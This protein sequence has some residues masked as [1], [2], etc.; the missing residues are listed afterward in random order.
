MHW[1]HFVSKHMR[2][3][4][5]TI[6]IWMKIDPYY[7][8]RRCS[9]VTIVSGNIKFMR[10]FTAVP[11]RRGAS[12]DSGSH[13]KRRFS[14]IRTLRFRNFSK[15]GQ[16]YYIVLFSPLSPFQ[17]FQNSWPWMAIADRD[18]QVCS[19]C[20]SCHNVTIGLLI[21]MYFSSKYSCPQYLR[22]RSSYN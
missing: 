13:R 16:Y 2:L 10:I 15:W 8:R 18:P 3:S 22:C 12:N 21:Y 9:T 11:W 7:Q 5:P 20:S 17:W 19:V 4:E 14:G 1:V 6:K